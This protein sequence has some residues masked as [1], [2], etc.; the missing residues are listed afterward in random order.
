MPFN[1]PSGYG[2][3]AHFLPESFDILAGDVVRIM[4]GT[5]PAP[6]GVIPTAR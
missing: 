1:V 5:S 2:A 6:E 4:P 3:S